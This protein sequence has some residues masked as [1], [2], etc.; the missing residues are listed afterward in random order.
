AFD[1]DLLISVLQ[2][3]RAEKPVHIPHYDMKTSTRVPDQSVRI[4]RP[5]VVLLEGILVL[6]D[7]RV[8]GLLSM[9][10]FVDE[11]SDTRLARR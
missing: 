10:I 4:E 7:A 11:D 2:D 1:W 6:F 3:I 8:R 5:A 9:A